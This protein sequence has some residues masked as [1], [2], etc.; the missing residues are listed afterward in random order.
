M[1]I[2]AL[3]DVSDISGSSDTNS[4]KA[5]RITLE[6]GGIM[7]IRA[8]E[9]LKGCWYYYFLRASGLI[10]I[11]RGIRSMRFVRVMRITWITRVMV[12]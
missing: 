2:S 4:L 12:L 11:M 9:V 6:L 10:V 1:M 7:V 8:I 5:V 3:S